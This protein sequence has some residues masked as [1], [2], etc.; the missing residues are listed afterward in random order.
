[1]RGVVAVAAVTAFFAVGCGS[2]GPLASDAGP[3]H[4]ATTADASP[5]LDAGIRI[6]AG[7]PDASAEEPDVGPPV[8]CDAGDYFIVVNY[9]GGSVVLRQGCGPA[10]VPTL[11]LSQCHCAEDC[12][13][14]AALICGTGDASSLH[15]G[16]GGGGPTSGVGAYALGGCL[17]NPDDSW[18][19]GSSTSPL[20]EG[21][22][23]LKTFPA[24]GTVSG[25]YVAT[26]GTGTISGTFCVLRA[27]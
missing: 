18:S 26:V 16:F 5:D 21:Q 27:Y 9:D 2:T 25:D 11:G 13:P 14:T 1:M 6:E 3:L 10:L 17:I 20:G 22:V 24:S 23:R 15:L 8:P 7:P 12:S 4:D 19:L